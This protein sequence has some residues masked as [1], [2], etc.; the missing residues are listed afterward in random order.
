MKVK[1]FCVQFFVRC[2]LKFCKSFAAGVSKY[3]IVI[4][5]FQIKVI[6]TFC[7]SS[8]DGYHYQ[9]LLGYSFSLKKMCF[10]Q[11]VQL[12]RSTRIGNSNERMNERSH[13]SK[14]RLQERT[15]NDEIKCKI[16]SMMISTVCIRNCIRRTCSAMFMRINSFGSIFICSVS[17][18]HPIFVID[19]LCSCL[20]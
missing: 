7:Q 10:I 16:K 4:K 6:V 5:K 20:K 18:Q 13:Q 3:P 11:N 14:R 15:S 1:I 17:L 19:V 9:I 2:K 8:V 12:K